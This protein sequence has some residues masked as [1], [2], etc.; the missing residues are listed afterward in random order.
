M[1]T[2]IVELFDR[3]KLVVDKSLDSYGVCHGAKVFENGMVAILDG[4]KNVSVYVRTSEKPLISG[5]KDVYMYKDLNVCLKQKDGTWIIVSRDAFFQKQAPDLCMCDDIS[6]YIV[7][8]GSDLKVKNGI[9]AIKS[10]DENIGW[11]FYSINFNVAKLPITRKNSFIDIGEYVGQMYR[12][13]ILAIEEEDP[14]KPVLLNAMSDYGK[15]IINSVEARNYVF[16]KFDG[17]S[18][19]VVSDGGINFSSKDSLYHVSLY[20]STSKLCLYDCRLNVRQ[21][22]CDEIVMFSHDVYF[23]RRCKD[24]T[25]YGKNDTVLVSDLRNLKFYGTS[26]VARVK[27]SDTQLFSGRMKKGV[28]VF[29]IDNEK[30]TIVNLLG[31]VLEAGRSEAGI[32]IL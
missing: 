20:D 4:N 12:S 32:E 8:R 1:K 23:V 18:N 26:F 22:D 15:G 29:W 6:E 30:I 24:W 10:F 7:A 3:P 2:R 31:A 28:I 14:D 17:M 16:L 11:E 21:K 9:V 27:D 5:Y 13:Y 19:F 25:L